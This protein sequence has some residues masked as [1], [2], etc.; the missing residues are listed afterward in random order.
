[1]ELRMRLVP[2]LHAAFVRYHREGVPPFRPLVMDYPADVLAWPV[3]DQYLIGEGLLAAP[4]VAGESARAVYLPEGDWYDFW[5][6]QRHAGKQRVEVAVPLEQVPLFVKAGT[7]LPLAEATLH[8][9]D[10]ASGHLTVRVYG[11]APATGVLYEDDGT[12]AGDLTEVRLAWDGQAAAGSL[13][14]TG[15]ALQPAYR[16]LEWKVIA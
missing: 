3:D 11:G 9:G 14:R 12:F 16:V 5:S 8:T 13:E 1:M 2:Y 15:P 6:G 7:L 10:P 4:V